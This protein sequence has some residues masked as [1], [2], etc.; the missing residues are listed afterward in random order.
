MGSEVYYLRE[1]KKQLKKRVRLEA[2][3]QGWHGFHFPRMR[4]V[5]RCL[6]LAGFVL[7]VGCGGVRQRLAEEG[8]LQQ[9][10][11]DY[12][13]DVPLDSLWTEAKA[14]T[15]VEHG[16]ERSEDGVRVF[17][18]PARPGAAEGDSAPQALPGILMRGWERDGRGYV[19]IFHVRYGAP[20]PR[21]DDLGA[22][23]ADLEL[24]LLARFHPEDARKFQ[25]GAR[26]AGQRAR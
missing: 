2:C 7:L 5:L 23:A 11:Y 4:H 9:Q 1:A 25:E 26:R 17:F 24:K 19:H 20:A 10:L 13:Y 15:G 16:E 18:I 22:R 6:S 8:Y 12:A 21:F 14:V 3:C